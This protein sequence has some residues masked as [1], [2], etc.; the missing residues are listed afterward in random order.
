M[1]ITTHGMIIKI[2]FPHEKYAEYFKSSG[3]QEREITKDQV[4][5]LFRQ[6]VID[7]REG[8]IGVDELATMSNHFY[9][10]FKDL[11]EEEWLSDKDSRIKDYLEIA[12]DLSYR[13]RFP[14]ETLASYLKDILSYPDITVT[15]TFEEK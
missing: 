5:G 10:Y 1:L 4:D 13:I 7:F 12:A 2:P 9:S 15:E 3:I 11:S 14:D 6:M 8:R